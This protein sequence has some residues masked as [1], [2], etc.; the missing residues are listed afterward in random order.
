VGHP[1]EPSVVTA[2]VALEDIPVY[3]ALPFTID[4]DLRKPVW[5]Q[6][7]RV[8][9]CYE[10]FTE[11]EEPSPEATA[12]FMLAWDARFLYLAYEWN[13][14]EPPNTDTTGEVTGPPGN[15]R[16]M[17]MFNGKKQMDC[18]EFFVDMNCDEFHFWE[19]HHNDQ[20]HFSDIFCIRP[21]NGHDKLHKF[22]GAGMPALLLRHCFIPDDGPFKLATAVRAK[23]NA[24]G[25]YQGYSAELRLPL[26]G[27]GVDPARRIDGDYNLA[28]HRFRIFGAESRCDKQPIYF[29]SVRGL[30]HGWFHDAV[31]HA[32]RFV[33][34]D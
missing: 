4:G 17:V 20:N 2:S 33:A 6:A 23:F 19:L 27:L 31:P 14:T 30:H 9:I 22:I 16:R 12:A 8:P 29:Q 7:V 25:Q 10:Y 3:K 32:N 15:R 34:L 21:R 13:S 24:S 11:R 5:Q 18:I 26:A 1:I 28:N